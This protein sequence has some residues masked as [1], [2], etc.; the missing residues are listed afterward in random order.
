MPALGRV[1]GDDLGLRGLRLGPALGLRA[2]E[3]VRAALGPGLTTFGGAK[4]SDAHDLGSEP[5]DT[6]RLERFRTG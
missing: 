2:P 3:H 5:Q 4:G 6:G 1:L